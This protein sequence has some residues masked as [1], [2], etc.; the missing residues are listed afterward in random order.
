MQCYSRPSIDMTWLRV[1]QVLAKRGSCMRRQVGCVLTD[2]TGSVVATGWNGRP[3]AMG[4]CSEVPCNSGCDGIHA[5][6]NA[7]LRANG[8]AR[9]AYVTHAPCWHCIKTI[10]NSGIKRI[11]YLDDSTLEIHTSR[12]AT[13][14]G[15]K[16]EKHDG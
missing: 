10:A 13:A 7:L 4:N 14:S 11:L 2:D 1:A 5:E 8:R 9:V 16:L 3:K 6:V 12:L 15:I